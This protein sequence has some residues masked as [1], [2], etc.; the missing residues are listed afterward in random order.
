MVQFIS[1]ITGKSVSVT[2]KELIY[3][4]ASITASEELKI[5][6]DSIIETSMPET[7]DIDTAWSIGASLSI[8]SDGTSSWSVEGTYQ[9]GDFYAS[10]GYSPAILEAIYILKEFSHKVE[11][12]F[13]NSKKYSMP[14]V[15]ETPILSIAQTQALFNQIQTYYRFSP[16]TDAEITAIALVASEFMLKE[17][18]EPDEAI[19]IAQYA[20]ECSKIISGNN[21]KGGFIK[22]NAGAIAAVGVTSTI[23]GCLSNPA[24][25][26]ASALLVSQAGQILHKYYWKNNHDSGNTKENSV[27]TQDKNTLPNN[28]EPPKPPEDPFKLLKNAIISQTTKYELTE[29]KKYLDNHDLKLQPHEGG[30][31]GGHTEYKH[32]GWDDIKIMDRKLDPQ[33][34]DPTQRSI[35]GSSAFTDEPTAERVISQALRD[36]RSKIEDWILNK[37]IDSFKIEHKGSIVIGRGII[38]PETIIT[39][40]TSVRVILKRVGN[41]FRILTA[42]PIN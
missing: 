28:P 32:I 42:F 1:G 7:E 16:K 2:T 39:D 10:A 23:L 30:A 35:K 15:K 36:N 11:H 38:D 33:K 34:Y 22:A 8:R 9:D 13:D 24:C 4:V 29:I 18:K 21:L 19:H 6:A 25:A 12:L 26:A 17:G 27:T 3:N 14:E 41:S 20:I 40:K 37:P 31:H 5:V